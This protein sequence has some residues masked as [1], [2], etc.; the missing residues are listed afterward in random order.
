MKETIIQFGEG[1]FLRGFVD[2]FIHKLNE[3]NLYDG[4]IVIVKPTD[5]GNYDKFI[6]QRCEYNL[7]LRGIEKEKE[8]CEHTKI[9]SVSRIL[10][11]YENFNE[12]L[13]LAENPDFRFI[14]SNTTEAGILFDENCKMTDTPPS[15][16]PAKL[17]LLLNRRFENNLSGFVLLPCELIDNNGDELKN[18]VIKYAELW[19]LGEDFIKWIDTENTFCN[20]LVDRIVTGFPKDEIASLWNEIGYE[21]KLLN[22]AEIYHLWVIDNDFE[23]ELPLVEGGFNVIWTDDVTP[24]KKRKV[25]LLNGAHTSMVCTA[26]LAGIE[27]VGE[28]MEDEEIFDFIHKC[29]YDEILPVLGDNDENRK[30]AIDILDRFRNPYIRHQL[31]AIVLNC[32]SKFAVRVLPSIIEHKDKF[33]EYPPHLVFSLS[34]LIYFYKNDTP[35]DSEDTEEF[36][37]NATINEILESAELWGADLSE[38]KNIVAENYNSISEKGIREALNCIL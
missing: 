19:G 3:Q 29:I 8:V 5:R 9:T 12:Y 13:A 16:F 34:A 31:R 10:S 6:E 32:V 27:T 21:D 26:L 17:T 14:I 4:R 37:K 2:Y 15:S 28:C 30:F 1:N 38:L 11:P 7:Y 18:C 33:G 22:T 23:A 20:T 24:Y 36:M 35:N 25:R